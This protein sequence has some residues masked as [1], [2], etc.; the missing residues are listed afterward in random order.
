MTL[1]HPTPR[2]TTPTTPTVP[3]TMTAPWREHLYRVGDRNVKRKKVKLYINGF[4]RYYASWYILRSDGVDVGAEWTV[5][6][7]KS[8]PELVGYFS[9]INGNMDHDG[10]QWKEA[11]AY[12]I[13]WRLEGV[14]KRTWENSGNKPW[15]FFAL[16]PPEIVTSLGVYNWCPH[17]VGSVH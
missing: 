12:L 17:C 8:C 1:F 9:Y 13:E 7:S 10:S 4:D 16:E 15:I 14:P 2:P 3:P 5:Q 6:L 11:D